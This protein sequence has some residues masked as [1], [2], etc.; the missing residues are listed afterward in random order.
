MLWSHDSSSSPLDLNNG[1]LISRAWWWWY[2]GSAGQVVT[3]IAFSRNEIKEPSDMLLFL[4]SFQQRK[5]GKYFCR[6]L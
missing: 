3:S 5:R 2:G 6:F 4:G 1:W